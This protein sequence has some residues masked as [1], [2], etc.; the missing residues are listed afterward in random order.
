MLEFGRYQAGRLQGILVRATPMKLALFT[1]ALVGCAAVTRTVQAPTPPP[2]QEALWNA[3]RHTEAAANGCA[4]SCPSKEPRC[5]DEYGICYTSCGWDRTDQAFRDALHKAAHDADPTS[6]YLVQ[7]P[8][9]P[10]MVHI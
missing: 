8:E 1:L 10:G 2:D 9:I 6:S 4:A 3:A 5:V 7:C